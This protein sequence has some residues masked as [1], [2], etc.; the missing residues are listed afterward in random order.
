MRRF[1]R[2][3]HDL[4]GAVRVAEHLRRS[5][6][7]PIPFAGAVVAVTASGNPPRDGPATAG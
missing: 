6:A 5:A 7:E 2:G 1:T 3:V 4:A